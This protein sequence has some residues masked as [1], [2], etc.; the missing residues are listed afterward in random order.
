MPAAAIMGGGI[1]ATGAAGAAAGYMGTPGLAL[2]NQS[3]YGAAGQNA[4]ISGIN[5]IQD[6][7]NAGPGAQQEQEYT[8]SGEDLSSLIQKYVQNNGMPTGSDT[9]NAQAFASN[10]FAPQ[11]VGLQQSFLQQGYAAN[12]NSA[13]MGRAGNDP[14]LQA[15]MRTSMMQQQSMLNAQQGAFGSQYAMNMPQQRIGLA[16]QRMSVLGGLASQAMANRQALVAS[17]SSMYGQGLQSQEYTASHPG[18]W[19]G[20]LTGLIG[21]AGAGMSAANSFS[22]MGGGGGMGGMSGGAGG[23]GGGASSNYY[24]QQG[25]FGASASPF[26]GAGGAAGAGGFAG[27]GAAGGAFMA[28]G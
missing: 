20:M 25:A 27:G 22:N 13:L 28:A 2:G 10:M 6:L 3:A 23:Y 14:I 12:Q 15:K 5:G 7:V 9:Q 16:G 24:A 1:L 19:S 18:G 17:G 4:A 26:S 21:G 8:Q 11:Q